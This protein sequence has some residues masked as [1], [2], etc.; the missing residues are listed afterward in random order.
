MC[1]KFDRK[2]SKITSTIFLRVR[3]AILVKVIFND[4]RL[5]CLSDNYSNKY[6]TKHLLL[7]KNAFI[8]FKAMG[9][10]GHV[11]KIIC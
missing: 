4:K 9:Q 6:L 8:Q 7:D 2:L 5:M 11:T 10:A 3:R 1:P